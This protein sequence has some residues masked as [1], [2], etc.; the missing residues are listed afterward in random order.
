MTVNELKELRASGQFH[1]ATYR[2]QG[3]IWEGLYI[4]RRYDGLRGFDVAGVF[5]KNDPNL[6][7]AYDI[8][9]DSGVSVGSFGNG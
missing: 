6:D 3:S 9:R 5:G 1:H 2:N 8:V 7:A 4:Y